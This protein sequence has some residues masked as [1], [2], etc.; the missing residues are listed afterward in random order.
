LTLSQATA[1]GAGFTTSSIGLPVTLSPGQGTILTV[2]FTPQASGGANGNVALASS[3]GALNIPLTGS[4]LLAGSLAASPASV[5]FGNVQVGSNQSRTISLTNGSS[6]SITISQASAA[7]SGFN[8]TGLALPAMLAAG[9]S[10][11]FTVTFAPTSGGA[12]NGNIAI[13]STAPNPSLNIVLSGSGVTPGSFAVNPS[14]INFGSVQVGNTQSH[15]EILTNSGGSAL[16]ISQATLTGPGFT[17]SG[18]N[19]PTT[20]NPGQSLTFTLVFTPTANGNANGNLTLSADGAVQS[21]A[22]SLTGSGT[23]PGQLAVSP[24]SLSFGNVT[25]GASLNKTGTL[26]SS[27]ASVTVSSAVSSNPEFTLTGLS[28]PATVAAGQSVTFSVRFAPQASGASSGSIS[29]TSNATNGPST[30]SVTGNGVPAPQHN[31]KLSWNASTSTV[32]GYNV[33]RGSQTGGPYVAVNSSPDVSTSYTDDSVTAGQTYYYVVTAV[34]G[35]GTE[36]V[37]SNQV[38]AVIPTP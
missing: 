7:G 29:F 19:V 6:S 16:N 9:Q 27:G 3:V 5:S 17:M 20:L 23:S 26:T 37:Y 21:L 1:T 12:A 10:T 18:L 31:V 28:L 14:S 22:I 33:Y 36:S 15:A 32:V 13:A 2:T 4:G 25:V 34:D 35:G 24:G 8:L 38:Q 11:S 30:A